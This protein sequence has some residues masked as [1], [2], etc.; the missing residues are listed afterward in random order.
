VNF[1]FIL[2]PLLHFATIFN[3]A[4]VAEVTIS[5]ISL[6][7]VINICC[8]NSGPVLRTERHKAYLLKGLQSLSESYEVTGKL[9]KPASDSDTVLLLSLHYFDCKYNTV[10]NFFIYEPH[11][12]ALTQ[13][14]MIHL[15]INDYST[16]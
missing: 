9:F 14:I 4:K 12:N 16:L 3:S 6:L 8:N 1:A 13:C 15:H 11:V 10:M 7:I 2:L 5:S